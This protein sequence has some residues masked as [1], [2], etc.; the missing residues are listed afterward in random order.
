MSRT[1]IR[2]AGTLALSEARVCLLFG[3]GAALQLGILVIHRS[4]ANLQ[5]K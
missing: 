3:I 4:K 5:S 1:I 2:A